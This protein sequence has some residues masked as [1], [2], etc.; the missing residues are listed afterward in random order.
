VQQNKRISADLQWKE[1]IQ[2]GRF[3]WSQN[4]TH[5]RAGDDPF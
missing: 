1:T 5:Y 2:K 3:R 4:K